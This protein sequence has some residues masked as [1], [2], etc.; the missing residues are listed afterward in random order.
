MTAD[1]KDAI[2]ITRTVVDEGE[3]GQGITEVYAIGDV[4]G[5]TKIDPVPHDEG[6]GL[7]IHFRDGGRRFIPEHRIFSWDFAWNPE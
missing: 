1:V 7:V 4:R 3:G 6:D 2:T 5:T